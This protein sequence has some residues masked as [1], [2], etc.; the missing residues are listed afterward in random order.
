MDDKTL[1]LMK[2]AFK[3]YYFKAGD[4]II[5]PTRMSEREFGYIPFGGSMIRHLSFKTFGDLYAL[6]V[7]EAPHSVYYSAAYYH[8]PTLPMHDKGWKGGDLIFDIDADNLKLPC[9]KDHDLWEC[10]NCGLKRIGLRPE[11]CPNCG[12]VSI[13]ELNWACEKCLEAA[14]NEALKLIEILMK[15]FG[16]NK[17][18][19]KTYFSGNMGYHITIESAEFEDLDQTAR[20]EIADYVSGRGLIPESIGVFKRATYEDLLKNLPRVGEPGWRGR[21]AISFKNWKV[22]GFDNDNDVIKKIATLYGKIRYSKFKKRLE[23]EA[24]NMGAVIDTMV[25]TDVHRIFRMPDTLHGETGLLKK[26]CDNLLDFDPLNEAV[27]LSDELVE[28][29]IDYSPKFRL[30]DQ[31][32]R[33]FK[34]EKVKLPLMAAVYL[35]GKGLARVI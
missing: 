17:S 27:V 25:T 19:I 28:V 8:E 12:E 21:L 33:T 2:Q 24:L 26:M 23:V 29:F 22:K 16:I 11:K 6:L 32:Y 15:D 30:K 1:A 3:Q 9:K 5:P 10:K 18:E 7:R 13:S 34:K 31:I 20:S 35:A 4:K 14:K